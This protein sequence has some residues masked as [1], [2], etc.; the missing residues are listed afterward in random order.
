[1][2][3][4][5]LGPPRLAGLEL[6]DAQRARLAELRDQEQRKC[7]RLD[8]DLRIARLDLRRLAAEERP[9]LQAIGALVDRMADLRAGIAKARITTRLGMLAVLEPGQRAALRAAH[10]G[11]PGGR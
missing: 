1:M 11:P 9:N 4:D 5:G 7:I 2:D 8:A 6:T 3:P 10:P